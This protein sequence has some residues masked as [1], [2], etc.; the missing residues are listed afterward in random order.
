M[1]VK[2]LVPELQALTRS[3]EEFEELAAELGGEFD[4]WGRGRRLEMDG[5]NSLKTNLFGAVRIVSAK[6]ASTVD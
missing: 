2:T 3:S 1:A 4:G 6:I 5:Q